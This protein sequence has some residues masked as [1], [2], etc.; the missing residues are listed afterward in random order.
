MIPSIDRGP[1]DLIEETDEVPHGALRHLRDSKTRNEPIISNT[2][3]EGGSVVDRNI[4][5]KED[6]DCDLSSQDLD[7]KVII[8]YYINNFYI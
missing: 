1:W 6:Y 5:D 3:T 4:F 7:H 2:E 8:A